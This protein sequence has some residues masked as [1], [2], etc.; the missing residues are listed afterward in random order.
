M[1][2]TTALIA[3]SCTATTTRQ[4]SPRPYTTTDSSTSYTTRR[5]SAVSIQ[6]SDF[7]LPHCRKYGRRL[8]SGRRLLRPRTIVLTCSIPAGTCT[9]ACILP[10]RRVASPLNRRAVP[11]RMPL[12]CDPDRP[13]AAARTSF[14]F[15]VGDA[16][17][18]MRLDQRGQ[19]AIP[20]SGSVL[21]YSAKHLI[22]PRDRDEPVIPCRVP[23]EVEQ[24]CALAQGPRTASRQQHQFRG[25][26]AA[27]DG[28]D[29][30]PPTGTRSCV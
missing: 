12:R 25:N 20:K 7:Y 21:S 28:L 4:R 14:A 9:G 2:A 3:F 17:A 27:C 24:N 15:N 18:S 8:I 29:R 19:S 16:V 1:Q 23:C 13:A 30:F 6:F 10:M 11:P 22:H 5:T 26:A